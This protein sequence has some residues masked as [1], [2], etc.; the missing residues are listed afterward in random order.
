[1]MRVGR[2]RRN[3]EVYSQTDFYEK[4]KHRVNH[5]SVQYGIRSA[6]Y[7]MAHP[8]DQVPNYVLCRPRGREEM[9]SLNLIA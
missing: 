3:I 1:M 4:S 9:G 8:T 2:G 7:C 5:Q 6:K